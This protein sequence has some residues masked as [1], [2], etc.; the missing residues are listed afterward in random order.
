MQ[1]V[2]AEEE[3]LGAVQM[4][5]RRRFIGGIGASIALLALHLGEPKPAVVESDVTT[6]QGFT[7]ESVTIN[8]TTYNVT[9]DA[10]G[11]HDQ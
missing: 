10:V 8:G 2:H 11:W 5:S 7:I 9:T 3:G 1:R 4:I 6:P